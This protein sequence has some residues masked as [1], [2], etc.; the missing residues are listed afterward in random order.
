[1]T[2]ENEALRQ[3]AKVNK[4]DREDSDLQT[5]SRP[6][7]TLIFS[8]FDI[9]IYTMQDPSMDCRTPANCPVLSFTY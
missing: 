3:K 2:S 4:E 1:M 5:E 7:E 9:I 6:L 8:G